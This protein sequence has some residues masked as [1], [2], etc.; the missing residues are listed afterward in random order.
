VAK[1]DT[2]LSSRTLSLDKDGFIPLYHQIQRALIERIQ[3]GEL[4]V[5]DCLPSEYEL[6]RAY[7]VSRITARQ[8]LNNLKSSGYA[9]S[10]KGR[11]TYV[12]QPKLEKNIMHLRGFTEEMKRRGMIPSSHLLEQSVVHAP[13]SLAQQLRVSTASPIL[14]LRR[15]RIGDGTPMALEES[16]I[17]LKHYPGLERINFAKNS[18]YAVLRDEYG[19]R[20][21]WADEVLE[22]SPATH[23]ESK[24]LS[25]PKSAIML[26]ISRVI[27]TTAEIPIEIACS[28]YCGDRYRASIRVPTTTIE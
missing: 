3:A 27:M 16:H 13:V 20:A 2:R 18:L 6:A 19:V 10:Q 5:G 26:S 11:G 17:P 8:A 7:Q 23:E 15:L 9:I 4:V 14:R 24:L 28:R 1:L 12:A 25:I 21:A 22:A